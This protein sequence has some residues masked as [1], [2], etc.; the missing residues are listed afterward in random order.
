[1]SKGRD[2]RTQRSFYTPSL[3]TSFTSN[4]NY[5]EVYIAEVPK[6]T[7]IHGSSHG[8]RFE[9]T[10]ADQSGDQFSKDTMVK[11]LIPISMRNYLAPVCGNGEGVTGGRTIM[12]SL[13]GE[14][15]WW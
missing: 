8:L 3:L 11:F 10:A 5:M 13:R 6:T 9:L 7:G 15:I 1:M 14:G 2:G 4:C 12:V